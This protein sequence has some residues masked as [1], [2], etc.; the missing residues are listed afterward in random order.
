MG[1][2]A[3]LLAALGAIAG[4]PAGGAADPEP[5]VRLVYRV[6]ADA[7]ACPSETAFRQRV[8]ELAGREPFAPSGDRAVECSFDAADGV[9]RATI[10]LRDETGTAVA[11]RSLR[12]DD[13]S[14]AQLSESASLIVVMAVTRRDVW[15]PTDDTAYEPPPAPASMPP[16]EPTPT[17]H[18]STRA[19]VR[20]SAATAFVGL[21]VG[22]YGRTTARFG[23]VVNLGGGLDWGRRSI[24]LELRLDSAEHSSLPEQGA[25]V[26][27]T[28]AIALVP[29]MR[30]DRVQAC[31]VLSAGWIRG[32]GD[33]LAIERSATTPHFAAG[34]RLAWSEPVGDRFALRLFADVESALTRTDLLIDGARVWTSPLG[35]ARLGIAAIAKFP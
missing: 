7:A 8:S 16:T 21:G 34:A 14:C 5:T 28:G 1:R 12:S 15:T 18:A 2:T 13:P 6:S 23:G 4:R 31:A 33:G 9:L 29:C 24:E 35:A 17:L 26:A 19:P 25:V 3:C 11:E 32:R 30:W 20:R 22:G 27:S 10:I